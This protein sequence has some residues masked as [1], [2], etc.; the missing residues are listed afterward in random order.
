MNPPSPRLPAR[1][2]L[3]LVRA[4][5]ELGRDLADKDAVVF[6]SQGTCMY[7]A[8]RPGD[9]LVIRSRRAADVRVGE[10][11]VCRGP[12]CLFGHR[13][14]E[15]GL[16]DGRPFI[17]TRPDRSGEGASDGPTFDENLLGV[18][19]EIRRKGRSAPLEKTSFPRPS[20]TAETRPETG[21]WSV[22]MSQALSSASTRR[23][24]ASPDRRKAARMPL[25]R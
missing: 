3:S 6:R 9:L 13:V 2:V 14:I 11:A 23:T 18:V 10:I 21:T 15:T 20:R 5:L 7:P 8:V 25:A 19:V 1:P 22:G 24:R 16:M 4:S 17:V 12:E